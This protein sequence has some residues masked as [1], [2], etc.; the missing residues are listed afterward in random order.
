MKN[1]YLFLVIFL[2][3]INIL[4]QS[5]SIPRVVVPI[6]ISNDIGS[7]KVL[8]FGLDSLASDDFD[9]IFGEANLPP[10]PPP[11]AWDT[12]FL[13]PEGGFSGVKSSFKDFRNAPSFPFTGSKEH[14]L[15]YQV[16]SGTTVTIAWNLPPNITGVLQ[17]IVIGTIINVPMTDSGSYIVTQ[18]TIF[19]K[20]KMTVNYQGVI[21]V[22]LVSFLASV[23]GKKVNL[24]W[25]TATELNN[26]GFEIQRKTENSNWLKIGFVNGFGTSTEKNYYSFSDNLTSNET[27]YYRLK[28]IDFNG[29]FSYSK[30]IKVD[31]I[32]PIE[33]TLSQ[34]FPNPFNPSTTISFSLPK[35]SNVKLIVYNQIGQKVTELVNKTHSAGTYNYTWNASQHSSG[36]YFYELQTDD[37]RSIRKMT[38]IK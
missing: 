36:I 2:F 9:Y 20:L 17:D 15:Q 31:F 30:V 28:Q 38:L 37:Y 25:Q 23:S 8:E 27:A 22:E 34:N 4:A 29:S 24:T 18:P 33:F 16:G 26:S 21:P 1:I 10:L 3:S 35:Q 14:R 11:T 13:L 32:N 5:D 12:R 19:N 6:T 7:L